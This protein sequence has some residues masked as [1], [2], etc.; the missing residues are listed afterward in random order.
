MS[1]VSLYIIRDNALAPNPL[2]AL[3]ARKPWS[4]PYTNL[5]DE[6]IAYTPLSG[7]NFISDNA[8]VFG[9]LN[10][11]LNSTTAIA[12]ISRHQACQNGRGDI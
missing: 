1:K 5:M 8:R 12:S 9:I 11:V 2:P 6:L 4:N 3:I 7:T 10:K